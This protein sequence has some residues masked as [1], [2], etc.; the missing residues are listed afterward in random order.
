MF[1]NFKLSE[2]PTPFMGTWTTP[3]TKKNHENMAF[4]TEMA[5][6]HCRSHHMAFPNWK[7]SYNTTEDVSRPFHTNF[8][9][10]RTVHGHSSCFL[11]LRLETCEN[12]DDQ[13]IR[14]G[15]NVI[16]TQIT[17]TQWNHHYNA[18]T[19]ATEHNIN[20]HGHEPIT[21]TIHFSLDITHW[22]VEHL[23]SSIEL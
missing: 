17:N 5:W 22:I 14:E 16:C 12:S 20:I 7:T 4:F 21:C 23:V 18:K 1:L 3:Q 13:Q 19:K 6:K 15:E 11:Q 2:N 10:S 9:V 8:Q